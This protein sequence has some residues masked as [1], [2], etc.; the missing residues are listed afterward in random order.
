MAIR[1]FSSTINND[2]PITLF[3]GMD[4]EN[5]PANTGAV[6]LVPK[7]PVMNPAQKPKKDRLTEV[8]LPCLLSDC[9]LFIKAMLIAIAIR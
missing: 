5:N 7:D 6:P 8:L 4:V 2:V 1:A 3:K 9:F